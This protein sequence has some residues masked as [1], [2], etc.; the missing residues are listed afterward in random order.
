MRAS[1]SKQIGHLKFVRSVPCRLARVIDNLAFYDGLPQVHRCGIRSPFE[2]DQVGIATRFYDTHLTGEAHEM[3]WIGRGHR[4]C[5]SEGN[6]RKT[7]D[8]LD[9]P[10]EIN[11]GPCQNAAPDGIGS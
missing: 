11:G 4:Y 8:V 1:W 7:N 5:L 2:N 9:A 3:G 10:K 6:A